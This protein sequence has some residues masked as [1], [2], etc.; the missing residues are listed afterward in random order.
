M[1]PLIS[2][3]RAQ[4]LITPEEII[5]QLFSAEELVDEL[6][7]LNLELSDKE[8]AILKAAILQGITTSEAVRNTL[9]MRIRQVLGVFGKVPETGN[10]EP[11]TDAGDSTEESPDPG[12]PTT[13]EETP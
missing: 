1:A 12:S 8:L 2:T 5:L 9:R 10:R 6:L 4:Q 11:S 13:H 3:S 7:F